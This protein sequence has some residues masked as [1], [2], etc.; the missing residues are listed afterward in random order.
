MDGFRQPNSTKQKK[1]YETLKEQYKKQRTALEKALKQAALIPDLQERLSLAE[2]ENENLGKLQNQLNTENNKN[3]ELISALATA[4][5]T[6][7]TLSDFQKNAITEMDTLTEN[8][9]TRDSEIET[10]RN[11]LSIHQ[12]Q[13]EKLQTSADTQSTELQASVT[14]QTDALESSQLKIAAL[15]KQLA[16]IQDTAQTQ[17]EASNTKITNLT[18]ALTSRDTEIATLQEQSSEG[19]LKFDSLLAAFNE[20]NTRIAQLEP[21]QEKIPQLE[22]HL[23]GTQETLTHRDN[24]ILTLKEQLGTLQNNLD[25]SQ[26]HVTELEPKLARITELEQQLTETQDALEQGDHEIQSSAMLS[27]DPPLAV[28]SSFVIIIPSIPIISLNAFA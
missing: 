28:P 3:A 26:A 15:K 7:L 17:L 20:G 8:I 16:E 13:L 22:K 10:L 6:Q 2:K 14:K 23:A 11:Q 12:S 1:R 18:N 21:M 25:T 24:E 27:T 9:T 19:Y 5:A 4:E